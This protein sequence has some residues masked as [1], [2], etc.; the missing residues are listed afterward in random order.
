MIG[1]ALS[2][3]NAITSLGS[4]QQPNSDTMIED[5]NI[6]VVLEIRLIE[7]M[8]ST[9]RSASSIMWMYAIRILFVGNYVWYG[10]S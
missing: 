8:Q 6:V 1:R 5:C 2:K 9:K 4:K 10:I 3:P 7:I